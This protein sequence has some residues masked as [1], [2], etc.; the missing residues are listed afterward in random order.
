MVNAGG[1]GE[2]GRD[3]EAQLPI[4]LDRPLAAAIEGLDSVTC[5]LRRNRV[6]L[7]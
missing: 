7:P 6:R 1:E 3:D 2:V 4:L 5:L